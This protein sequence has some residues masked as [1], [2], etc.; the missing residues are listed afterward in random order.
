[1]KA[2]DNNEHLYIKYSKQLVKTRIVSVLFVTAAYCKMMRS[3]I[4]LLAWLPVV[5]INA[6][7]AWSYFA[8]MV[9]FGFGRFFM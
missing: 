2:N 3:F 1:M 5:I 6:I 9:I 8:Y 7:I 4:K